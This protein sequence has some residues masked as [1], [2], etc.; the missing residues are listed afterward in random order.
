[1]ADGTLIS[2]CFW[3]GEANTDPTAIFWDELYTCVF[4]GC[5]DNDHG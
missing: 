4:E 5:L 1:M 2:S 3:L